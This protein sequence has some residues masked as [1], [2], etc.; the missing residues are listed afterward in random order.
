MAKGAKIRSDGTLSFFYINPCVAR[1]VI[2]NKFKTKR[3]YSVYSN[4]DR[5][6]LLTFACSQEHEER[7]KI[8]AQQRKQQQQQHFIRSLFA[9]QAGVKLSRQREIGVSNTLKVSFI[10][11]LCH[12]QI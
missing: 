11:S 4:T 9:A 1:A 12:W 10:Y 7:N 6:Q 5:S 2:K 3:V 8:M